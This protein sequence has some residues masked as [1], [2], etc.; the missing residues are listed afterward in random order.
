MFDYDIA[1]AALSDQ[2]VDINILAEAIKNAHRMY[3]D[4]LP[5][6]FTWFDIYVSGVFAGYFSP[7]GEGLVWVR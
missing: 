1:F 3:Y 2:I 7:Q 4:E 5:E 6:S